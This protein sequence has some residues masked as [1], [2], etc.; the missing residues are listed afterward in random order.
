MQLERGVSNGFIRSGGAELLTTMLNARNE[1][2]GSLRKIDYEK[3]NILKEEINTEQ[4]FQSY[5]EQHRE[6]VC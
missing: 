1:T 6:K 2:S 4:K 3:V 5:L